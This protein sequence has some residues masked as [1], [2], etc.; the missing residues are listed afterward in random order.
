MT[1]DRP[2]RE[3]STDNFLKQNNEVSPTKL[4]ND[5]IP[6]LS[7]GRPAWNGTHQFPDGIDFS[8]FHSH[9]HDDQHRSTQIR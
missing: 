9:I 1:N 3:V 2:C 7:P 5:W 6:L 4:D 8:L